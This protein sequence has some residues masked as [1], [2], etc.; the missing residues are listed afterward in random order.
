MLLKLLIYKCYSKLYSKFDTLLKISNL[1]ALLKISGQQILLKIYRHKR[2]SKFCLR[3][4]A[5]GYD[6]TS[7]PQTL[8]VELRIAFILM[9]LAIFCLFFFLVVN[10]NIVVLHS[11]TSL[12]VLLISLTNVVSKFD[13]LLK[14]SNPQA[15]LKLSG[16]KILLKIS[17]SNKGIRFNQW[18]PNTRGRITF[19]LMLLANGSYKYMQI[20]K[21]W[22]LLDNIYNFC[23]V[24]SHFFLQI[25]E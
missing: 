4:A 7:E 12:H 17:Q 25:R 8:E 5:R 19:I 13:T 18:T 9:L 2:F 23:L 1:Q 16:L 20:K 24:V 6:L 10:N 11:N 3:W 15:L 22:H 21:R 14:I